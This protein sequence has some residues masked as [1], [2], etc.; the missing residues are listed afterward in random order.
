MG[1]D[2]RPKSK[3][4]VEDIQH[5]MLEMMKWFH[6]YCEENGIKYYM[7]GGTMLG[8]ARHQGFI[9]WDDDVDIGVPRNDYIKL[10]TISKKLESKNSIYI[11]ES[12]Q[13]MNDDYEYPFAKVY[14]T[15]T[16]LIE[17]KRKQTKRGIYIDVFPLDGIKGGTKE[18]AIHNYSHL[19]KKLNWL[20]VMTSEVRSG[21][22]WWKNLAVRMFR[23]LPK[24]FYSFHSLAASIDHEC[25]SADFYKSTFA[26]NLIGIWREKEILP[27]QYFGVPT[28]YKFEDAKFYGVAEP[29]KYLTNV[30]GDWRALPPTEK[31]ISHHDYIEI[32]LQKSYLK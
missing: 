3:V 26:G 22:A 27:Q 14:D 13:D 10:L 25:A 24:S 6:S 11:I 9:P 20:A 8:A 28:L 32:N 16:T 23:V 15:T 12:Y 7:I 1:I 21:R 30:Y 31:Q 2:S 29:D 4:S 18:E 17:N 5:K 19:I